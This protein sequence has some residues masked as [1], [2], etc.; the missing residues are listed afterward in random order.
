MAKSPKSPKSA[1]PAQVATARAPKNSSKPSTARTPKQSRPSSSARLGAKPLKHPKPTFAAN[2][3]KTLHLVSNAHLD[4]IWQWEWPEGA[5]EALSTFR[6]AADLCEEFP[7]YVFNHNEVILYEW[8]EEYEPALF[9]RIQKLVKQGRWHIM[10][11]WHVQPDC[12]MPSGES[13]VRQMLAGRRYFGKKFGVK[14]STAINFDPFGHS[15]GLVQILAK[16]GYTSYLICRPGPGDIT[17]PGDIFRWVGYDGSEVVCERTPFFYGSGLGKA[18]EKV[19]HYMKH[20]P[21]LPVGLLLWGVGNHG[22]GPSR[23]DLENLTELIRTSETHRIL[24]STPEQYFEQVAR[25]TS[26]LPSVDYA[27]NPWAVGCYTSL[28]RIKQKHRQL[29]NELFAAEKMASAAWVQGLMEYPS[30]ELREAQRM[31]L[32]C[33]FHDVLPGSSVQPSEEASLNLLGYGLELVSRVRTRAFFALSAGQPKPAG[34]DIPVLVYNPHAFDIDAVVECEF[35]LQDQNWGEGFTNITVKRKSEDLPT[36]VEKEQ[37]SIPLDWRKRVAFRTVLKASQMNRFDCRLELMDSKPEFPLP[38]HNGCLE[39]KTDDL[40]VAINTKTGLVDRYRIQGT[41]YLQREAFKL[42]VISDNSD[43][44]GM[45]VRSFRQ[46][47]GA[48][49]LLSPEKSAEVAG[50]A[51]QK[52]GPVHVIERGPV[53]TVIEAMFG[54]NDSFAV[55]TYKIPAQGTEVE[56][57]VRVLWNEKDRMLK[58]SV[59]ATDEKSRY[60]GE[61][62]YGVEELKNDGSECVSQK[63]VAAMS[64]A[65]GTAVTLIN[66]GIYGSD[67]ADGEIRL[68]LL[69][70]PAYCAHPLPNRVTPP[71]DRFVARADQGERQ[72]SVWLN[73]GPAKERLEAVGREALAKNEKPFALSFFPSGQGSLPK[74]LAKVSGSV[75]TASS[76]KKS[77]EGNDLIVRLFEPSGKPRSCVVDL[78]AAGVKAS[79]KLGAFEIK[80]LRIDPR[81]SQWREVDLMEDS[82]G[83]QA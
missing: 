63:W 77:E 48:F 62:M 81:K 80:T 33:Q 12:N 3:T 32:T 69:R 66:E 46:V 30:E 28:V 16:S 51:G 31:L 2:A 8:I 67:C 35:I 45:T 40:E 71:P 27:L 17:L 37:S 41:D 54:W 26:N 78:P 74:P 55:V 76:I 4:P 29:E 15:R 53:R 39:V 58:L 10:G 36:Q 6:T 43:P 61:V 11:G 13:M 42:L 47:L 60:L 38:E 23:K 68:S 25:E 59:P 20:R 22:G 49:T 79:V 56:V 70:S 83:K 9:K 21:D 34:T 72:F 18:H 73:A 65:Q 57:Q 44:W 1:K 19:A 7:G 50:L 75:V 52:L 24:H 64:D 82:T 14:P 5:A